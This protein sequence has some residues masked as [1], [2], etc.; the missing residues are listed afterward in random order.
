VPGFVLGLV[1]TIT[2]AQMDWRA[3][4]PSPS[5]TLWSGGVSVVSAAFIF[6]GILEWRRRADIAKWRRRLAARARA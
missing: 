2:Q 1:D 3:F 6:C 4:D 5:L